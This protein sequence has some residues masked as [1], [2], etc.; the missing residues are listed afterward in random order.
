MTLILQCFESIRGNVGQWGNKIKS[1][2]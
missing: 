1:S 2:S